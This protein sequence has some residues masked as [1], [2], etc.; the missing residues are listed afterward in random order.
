MDNAAIFLGFA[1]VLGSLTVH[2]W[3]HAWTADRLGDPTAR[4]LGRVSFNPLVHIDPIGTVLLPLVG[5]LAAGVV[6]G[7]A[8]PVP[9][10]VSR[11]GHPKRDFMM[12]AAAGPASNIVLAIAAALLFR[13]LGGYEILGTTMG[14][15]VYLAVSMNIL[16]AVFNMLPVPPLDGGNVLAGLLPD[17]FAPVIQMLRQFGFLILLALIF[18]GVLN[19]V[20][21][22]VAD[23]IERLLI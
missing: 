13:A 4:M 16:L 14:R 23:A 1:I 11:L 3:A 5:L 8:K 2:E 10:N 19:T 18:S 6:F 22:P 9:V 7:W 17:G 21:G 15:A 12:V 20:V